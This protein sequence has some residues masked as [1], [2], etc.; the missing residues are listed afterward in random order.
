MKNSPLLRHSQ[1][2]A[3]R[4]EVTTDLTADQ[5]HHTVLGATEFV[6]PEALLRHDAASMPAP[7]AI[8]T[9]LRESLA[10]DPP[11]PPARWWR[12]LLGG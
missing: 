5:S 10:N 3:T 2:T 1:A 12:R 6:S 7:P 11:S 9:R 8:A 4:S